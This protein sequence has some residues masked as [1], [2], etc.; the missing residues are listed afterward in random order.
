MTRGVHTQSLSR[1]QLFGTPSF[2]V[3]VIFQARILEW[4][5]VSS[6]R[7]L[8]DP[9]I[10]LACPALSGGFWPLGEPAE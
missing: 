5:A 2:S 10:E 1:V 3:H 9:G 8:P 7:D 6:S 4:A